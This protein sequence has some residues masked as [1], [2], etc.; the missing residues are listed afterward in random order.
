MLLDTSIDGSCSSKGI[1]YGDRNTN[2]KDAEGR[3]LR[4]ERGA[5]PAEAKRIV[6]E[7]EG[8]SDHGLRLD[9][10][11]A[12]DEAERRRCSTTTSPVRQHVRETGREGVPKRLLT[13]RTSS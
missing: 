12:D 8:I 5:P 10:T 1:H 9:C 11:A 2:I 6:N 4:P 3:N 13:R 7:L